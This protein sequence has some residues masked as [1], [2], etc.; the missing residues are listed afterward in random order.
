[1]QNEIDDLQRDYAAAKQLLEEGNSGLTIELV[2]LKMNK[3]SLAVTQ[4]KINPA[5]QKMDSAKKQIDKKQAE[6]LLIS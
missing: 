4:T 6:V 1:M 3:Q 2:K 5:Q